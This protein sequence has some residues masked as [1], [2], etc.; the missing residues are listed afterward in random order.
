MQNIITGLD[1]GS[2]YI[3][4]IVV[5]TKKGGTPS[6]ITAFKYPSAGFR[7]GMLVDADAATSVLSD[8]AR[9]I[10]KISR[11]AVKNVFVNI[12]SEHVKAHSSRGIVAVS[13]SDF[14]I[15]QDDIDRVVQASQAMKLQPN[16]IMLHNITREYFVDDVGDILDPVGMT[17]SRLEVSSLV[18][19]GFAPQ[20][21]V[22]TKQIERAGMLVGGLIFNPLASAKAVL[23]KRQKDLGV[24]LIDFGSD[25]TSFAIFQENKIVQTRSLPVGSS[26][27]TK[28]IAIGLKTS[29]DV[30]EQLKV[31]S[32]FALS[33]DIPR[34]DLVKLAHLD[35]DNK[36]RV[37]KKFLS[38]II[39]ERLADILDV[40][41]NELKLLGRTV[42]LPGGAVIT[43]GG[44]KLAGITEFVRNGLKLSTQIGIPD[45]SSFEIVNPTH[46]SLLSDPE[47]GTAVG[48]VLWG[49]VGDRKPAHDPTELIRNIFRNLMP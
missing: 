44:V 33:R 17:G 38:E 15:Q 35:P 2:S 49:M 8:I 20:V 9:D 1:V 10:E 32:G 5:D 19:E 43:G 24:I 31:E 25:T 22:L 23:S 45:V 30:A 7:K 28:D 27:I 13:R 12:N 11:H 29:I 14:E 41:N 36:E 42:Q 47:F 4:G 37:T 21:S 6:V 34:H 46:Q 18:V 40:V 26:Y 48:L 16:R 3:K 39:E